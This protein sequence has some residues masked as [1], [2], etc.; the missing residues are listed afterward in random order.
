MR[1]LKKDIENYF[2]TMLAMIGLIVV[3]LGAMSFVSSQTVQSLGPQRQNSC[4]DLKQ[5]CAN[6]TFVNVT[7]VIYPNST[8]ALGES[9]MDKIGTQYNLTFCSTDAL[10]VY[11]YWTFGDPDGTDTVSGV[12]FPVTTIGT[13][14]TEG[15]SIGGLASIFIVIFLTIFMGVVTIMA[16]KSENYSGF[17]IL[18]GGFTVIM[19]L[20]CLHLGYVYTRDIGQLEQTANVMLRMYTIGLRVVGV[21]AMVGIFFYLVYVL[22]QIRIEKERKNNDDG[23]QNPW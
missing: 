10:G 4:V 7:A 2:K 11:I 22:K 13:E 20:V 19:I 6:C 1:S 14:T 5:T 9:E 3:L 21:A 12:S 18:F 8:Q 16:A 23:W 15:E 17:A